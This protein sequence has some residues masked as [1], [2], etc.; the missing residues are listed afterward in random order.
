MTMKSLGSH[1]PH[2]VLR[3]Y[4]HASY[5]SSQRLQLPTIKPKPQLRN[6]STMAT[7]TA[8]QKSNK[9]RAAFIENKGPSYGI[10]V[11][12]AFLVPRT[13]PTLAPPLQHHL[14]P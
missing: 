12:R 6:T 8:M 3:V 2:S 1:T 11:T 4:V 9:L 14:N 7:T 10:W 5:P 13:L